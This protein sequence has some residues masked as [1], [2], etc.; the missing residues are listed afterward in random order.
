MPQTDP[1]KVNSPNR[2]LAEEIYDN[3]MSQIEPELTTEEIHT[4]DEKYKDETEE[5][6]KGRMARYEKA[7]AHFDKEVDTFLGNVQEKARESKRTSLKKKEAE[8]RRKEEA[9][10]NNLEEAF[11]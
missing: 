1:T 9:A 3:I 11:E 5:Q 2:K 8:V 6:R 4:L 10:L 7:Y